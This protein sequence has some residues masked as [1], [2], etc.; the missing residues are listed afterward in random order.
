M[1]ECF[2]ADKKQDDFLRCQ[3]DEGGPLDE[4]LP[5]GHCDQTDKRSANATGMMFFI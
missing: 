3:F 1:R 4:F 2:I 5:A